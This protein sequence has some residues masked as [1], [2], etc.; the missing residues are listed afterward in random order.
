MQVSPQHPATASWLNRPFTSTTKYIYRRARSSQL[1]HANSAEAL[2]RP[3]QPPLP[4]ARLLP[5][6]AGEHQQPRMHWSAV[7][8]PVVFGTTRVRDAGS[9]AAVGLW[10]IISQWLWAP[11]VPMKTQARLTQGIQAAILCAPDPYCRKREARW[12]YRSLYSGDW[13]PRRK[14]RA[15]DGP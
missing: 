11:D 2:E 1:R 8:Q 10:E 13:R 6:H 4:D 7:Q 5:M 14:A 9:A 3:F 12:A 15:G